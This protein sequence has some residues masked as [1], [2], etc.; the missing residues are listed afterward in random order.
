MIGPTEHE[1][2]LARDGG[3][4]AGYITGLR[5]LA[6][7]LE[8]HPEV[9]LPYDGN[10]GDLAINDFLNT[11]SPREDLAAA[12]RAFPIRWQKHVRG[13][14]EGSPDYFDLK[15]ELHGLKIRL[16]AYRDA[17]CTKIVTGTEEREVEKVITPAVTETVTETVETYEWVCESVM[18]PQDA[19]D[20]GT[21]E[22]AEVAA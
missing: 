3:Q 19:P 7:I 14:V 2:D 18:A 11:A 20:R 10:L 9:P 22:P 1:K 16:T 5:A 21:R 12:A 8:N 17:V 15:G 6:D 4:R 13:T